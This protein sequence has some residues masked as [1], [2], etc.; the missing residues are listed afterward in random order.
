MSITDEETQPKKPNVDKMAKMS[1]R[2]RYSG[3]PFQSATLGVLVYSAASNVLSV[4]SASCAG[5]LL[6]EFK[7]AC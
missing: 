3:K 4:V 2:K 1:P 5:S 6:R 7:L